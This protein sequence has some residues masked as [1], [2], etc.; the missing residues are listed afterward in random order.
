MHCNPLSQTYFAELDDIS[1]SYSKIPPPDS[2]VFMML[3]TFWIRY[4]YL[5]FQLG[6]AEVIQNLD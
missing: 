4:S 2:K 6:H 5:S 3:E 1:Y